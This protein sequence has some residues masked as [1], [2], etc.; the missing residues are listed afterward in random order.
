MGHENQIICPYCSTLYE[1]D[2]TLAAAA[3]EPEGCVYVA[4]SPPGAPAA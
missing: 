4:T 2:G 1:Y 3:S